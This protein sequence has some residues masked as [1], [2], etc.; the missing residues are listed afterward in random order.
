MYVINRLEKLYED[1]DVVVVKAPD[2]KKLVELIV[3]IIKRKG[4]PVSWSEFREALT[5]L[6]GEDRLRKTLAELVERG[7][8]VELPDGC[9][10]LPG[11][12][13]MVDWEKA[14]KRRFRRRFSYLE[15]KRKKILVST[16]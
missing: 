7:V 11:M 1:D 14:R 9:F 2:D 10:A 4:K 5:G 3:D 12:E 15:R 13:H 8:V 16:R 6:A